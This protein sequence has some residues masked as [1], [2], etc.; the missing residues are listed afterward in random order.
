M[1]NSKYIAFFGGIGVGKTT[2]GK[3]LSEKY[4]NIIFLE[5]NV[6]ENPFID[7][8]YNDMKSYGFQ[9]SIAM[10]NVMADYYD[11]VDES[12]EIII[13]DQGIDELI[14]Y[15][16]LELE[17]GILSDKEYYT[18]LKLYNRLRRLLPQ[19]NLYVYFYCEPDVA[20]ERIKM[21][22]R[23]EEENIKIDFLINLNKKYEEWV[24]Q[25]PIDKVLRIDT[26][27]G[28]EI[29]EVLYKINQKLKN[30]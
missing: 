28:V 29:E 20:L 25:I 12:K 21:R 26:T 16:N 22:G 19:T 1:S 11:R 24:E 18:Y 15:T 27:K 7:L 30:S 8:F 3:K 23:K 17:M 2:T 9:S 6:S 5:E 4:E 13:L 10:L 14:C